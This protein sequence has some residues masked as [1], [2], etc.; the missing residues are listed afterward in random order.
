MQPN[1]QLSNIQIQG[2]YL[3]S[4][5]RLHAVYFYLSAVKSVDTAVGVSIYSTYSLEHLAQ[6]SPTTIKFMQ[7]QLY[8]DRQ[9]MVDLLKRAEKAGY[10]AII[11]TV[12]VPVLVFGRH[13]DRANF[14]VPKHLRGFA[15]FTKSESKTND[16]M[17]R[18][19][20]AESDSGA[21][22]ETFDWLRSITSLPFVIK[23]ITTPEDA[24]LAVQHGAQGILVSNHGGWQLDGLPATVCYN[25][26]SS[27]FIFIS[28]K[29][30]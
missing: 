1:N 12:D 28:V 13:K 30:P 10:K 29:E 16:Q 2:G 9:L 4:L 7:I 14:S 6:D 25:E 19:V 24:R 21:V 26:K 20:E 8:T 3:L 27:P 17:S 18:Y 5:S 22:W 23:G 11:L 15:N